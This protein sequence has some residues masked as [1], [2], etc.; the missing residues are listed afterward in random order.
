MFYTISVLIMKLDLGNDRKYITREN[1]I[2]TTKNQNFSNRKLNL[3]KF[4]WGQKKFLFSIIE[5]RQWNSKSIQR[6]Q[7][8]DN[9]LTWKNGVVFFFFGEAPGSYERKK[10]FIENFHLI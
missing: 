6:R 4:S 7:K 8:A 10:W 5:N 3:L 9:N 1:T 2:S